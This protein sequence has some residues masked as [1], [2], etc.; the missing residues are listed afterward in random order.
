MLKDYN[1]DVVIVVTIATKIA[2]VRLGD[3]CSICHTLY[4]ICPSNNC[5]LVSSCDLL[6]DSAVCP[7]LGYIAMIFKT[8][9]FDTSDIESYFLERSHIKLTKPLL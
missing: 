9:P 5:W 2:L 4:C 1:P 8:V 6:L 3:S 7:Y